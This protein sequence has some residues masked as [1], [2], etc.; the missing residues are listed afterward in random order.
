MERWS[1]R[2]R[3]AL[4]SSICSAVQHMHERGKQDKFIPVVLQRV[5]KECE[6]D[7]NSCVVSGGIWFLQFLCAINYLNPNS[8]LKYKQFLLA[9]ARER[10]S[11]KPADVEE[12]Q[13][14]LPRPSSSTKHALHN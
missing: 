9:L 3:R 8:R 12:E 2:G 14:N 6:V 10:I 4:G 5:T 1:P 7:Q 13:S 11:D